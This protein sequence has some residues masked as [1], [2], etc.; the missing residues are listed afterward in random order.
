M[1]QSA[2]PNMASATE[3][4]AQPAKGPH[5]R[6]LQSGFSLMARGEPKIW[7]TGGMLVICLAMIVSLLTLIVISGLATFWPG[8]IDW[9]LLT[10]GQM[11][12]GEPQRTEVR[13]DEAANADAGQTLPSYFYRTANFDVTNRHYRWLEPAELTRAGIV[14][15]EWAL[16][17]ERQ[18][19]GRMLALPARLVRPI[20]SQ[21]AELGQLQDASLLLQELAGDLEALAGE[22][23]AL[24]WTD[25]LA[26]IDTKLQTT[27]STS[28]KKAITLSGKA[29]ATAYSESPN[30]KPSSEIIQWR[31]D[32]S[33]DWVN[34]SEPLGDDVQV[35][36]A[37][38]VIDDPALMLERIGPIL[39]Q[40]A[41]TRRDTEQA[42]H[43]ISVLDRDL[44]DARVAVRQ[45]ELD[46]GR[47][48]LDRVDALGTILENLA[49]AD[50]LQARVQAVQKSA[51][52][53]LPADASSQL[54]SL[55]TRYI[56]KKLA[57]DRQPFEQELEAWKQQ[58]A[59]EPAA[60]RTAIDA[61]RE[62]W[63]DTLAKKKPLEAV[64]VKRKLHRWV[65]NCKCS[66][67]P[68]QSS[69]KYQPTILLSC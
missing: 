15:P 9:L 16:V 12:I 33:S 68:M 26:A 37:R 32:E 42:M 46:T 8:P 63:A 22:E 35:A 31:P 25:L 5:R 41:Q 24:P 13:T 3:S 30:S 27:R 34:T 19:W 51:T 50:L 21:D 23:P 47:A 6:T 20:D 11:D 10:D 49:I 17:I 53:W 60:I 57:T 69:W 54:Q 40:L 43:R 36:Q 1:S 14:R 55:L 67:Q 58:F 66:C 56:E 38:L 65:T 28:I 4:A 62:A 59:D 39:N 18:S 7:L 64:F 52:Q 45:A 44:S 48:V 29:L 61:F 2:S